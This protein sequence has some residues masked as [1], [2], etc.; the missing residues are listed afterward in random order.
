MVN[1]DL[2]VP[3]IFEG[4]VTHTRRTPLVHRFHYR[5]GYWLVDYDHLPQPHGW[6][7][8][9]A[10]V[11]HDDHADVRSL[12]RDEGID[13]DRILLLATAR[14]LG[15]V[16]NPISVFWCYDASGQSTGVLAEVHNTYGGRHVYVLKGEESAETKVEK[17]L[18]VSPFYSV[19]GNYRIRVSQ[20]GAR[21]SVTVTLEQEGHEPFVATL[22][23]TRRPLT[24]ANVVRI[25]LSYSAL[26]TSALIRWQALRLWSRGLKF[27]P[28]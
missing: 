13:A 14:T 6:M 7:G 24:V 5:A 10:R 15:Y 23:A 1:G 3:A 18:Y 17:E 21:L 11:R 22:A 4:R 27:V 16:F 12:L 25:S 2:E 20:P 26:R 19:E 9:V 28:R 8:H